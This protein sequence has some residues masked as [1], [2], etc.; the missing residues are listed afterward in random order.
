[1]GLKIE[2]LKKE[3]MSTL[4]PV[5][6]ATQVH[7]DTP[8]ETIL[9]DGVD[10]DGFSYRGGKDFDVVKVD[11]VYYRLEATAHRTEWTS[12]P[13]SYREGRNLWKQLDS[14]RDEG[15]VTPSE[16]VKQR[17]ATRRQR[18]IERAR[19]AAAEAAEATIPGAP[20][21]EDTP[22]GW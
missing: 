18:K 5:F 20:Q 8:R 14:E 10:R 21:D 19:E 7:A 16:V 3:K 9:R 6:I 1:M 13:L 22:G 12:T 2:K 4:S 15:W 11:G 17:A